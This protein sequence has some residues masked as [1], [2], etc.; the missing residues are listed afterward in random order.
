M[1]LV[2]EGTKQA[3]PCARGQQ[4]I[5]AWAKNAPR[6]TLP[7]DV[8]FKVGGRDS[9]IKYLVLQ[10]HYA[11]VEN[12][13]E[14]GDRSGVVLTYTDQPQH[15]RAGVYF[16]GTGGMIAPQTTTYMEAAC[17]LNTNLDI[18]PFAFRY[19]V[20]N[21]V[22]VV[23]SCSHLDNLLVLQDPHT[24]S[25]QGSFWLESHAGDGVEPDREG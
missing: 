23:R 5:Y 6:L 20:V 3:P 15:K 18:H 14:T 1:G 19:V 7:E 9:K 4:I 11:S 24:R 16:L 12:I 17:R 21:V 8:G 25:G 2:L 10:V 22:N 13:P